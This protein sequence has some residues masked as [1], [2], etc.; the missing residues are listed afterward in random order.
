MCQSQEFDDCDRTVIQQE[1]VS[2]DLQQCRG[3]M[4]AGEAGE[5]ETSQEVDKIVQGRGP[6]RTGPRQ[7]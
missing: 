1:G 4:G 7:G 6:L 2:S 3:R 5:R